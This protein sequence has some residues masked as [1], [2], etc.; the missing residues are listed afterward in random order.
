MLQGLRSF[1]MRVTDLPRATEWYTAVLGKP[2]YFN[3]PFYVGFDVGGYELG[4]HP[5]EVAPVGR[6]G[7][8]AYW[9]VDDADAAVARLL[10]H[11]ATLEDPVQDVGGGIRLGT[12][13]DPFGNRIGVIKN[14][15][16]KVQ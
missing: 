14:P 9:G 16:F 6:G 12:V 10:E 1:I 11:G 3:E 13:I 5:E 7:G 15:H 4:L 2:P 8:A